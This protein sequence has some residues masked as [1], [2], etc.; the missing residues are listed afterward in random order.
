M[1]SI[2][3]GHNVLH[4][5]TYCSTTSDFALFALPYPLLQY[6]RTAALVGLLTLKIAHKQRWRI[7]AIGVLAA[8]A[9]GEAWWI[10][11]VTIT[12]NKDYN[13]VMVRP[14]PSFFDTRSSILIRKCSGTTRSGHSATPSSSSSHLSSSS[15]LQHLPQSQTHSP[16]SR[17]HSPH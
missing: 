11:T 17:K 15:S 8:A 16:P 12:V 14:C 1:L 13:G 7:P 4:D 6:L 9:A 5:C 3:Y 10:S 2:R